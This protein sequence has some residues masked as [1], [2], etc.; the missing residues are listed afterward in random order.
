MTEP[1][2][3]QETPTATPATITLRPNGPMLIQGDVTII[4]SDGEELDRG[5]RAA[6][7]R[8]GASKNKPFCDMSHKSSGFEG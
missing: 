2:A 3:P 6:F 8:C 7:C 4:G 1:A 5:G